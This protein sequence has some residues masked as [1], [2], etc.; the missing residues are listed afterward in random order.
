MDPVYAAFFSYWILGERF[1]PQG[2]LGAG[3]V[4]LGVV[5]SAWNSKASEKVF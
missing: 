3:L 1:G 4:V 2:V 5:L